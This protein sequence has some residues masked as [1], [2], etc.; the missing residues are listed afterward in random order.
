MTGPVTLGRRDAVSLR[1]I[2]GN[3]DGATARAEAAMTE[4][5]G[6][7]ASK[8]TSELRLIEPD[9]RPQGSGESGTDAY[10]VD[11]LADALSEALGGRP[12]DRAHVARALHDFV[13]EGATLV[14]ARPESGSLERLQRA[15]S[16]S[17]S[18]PAA[19]GSDVEQATAMIIAATNEIRGSGR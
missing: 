8:L 7:I 14:A 2:G 1:G 15:I 6:R 17:V 5:A 12:A 3:R 13:L 4:V 19:P 9:G 11:A 16:A 10:G 18:G